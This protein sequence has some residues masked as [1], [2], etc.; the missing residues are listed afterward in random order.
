[1]RN[2]YLGGSFILFNLLFVLACTNSEKKS[3]TSESENRTIEKEEVISEPKNKF[4]Q[5]HMAQGQFHRWLT[6]NERPITDSRIKNQLDLLNTKMKIVSSAGE[7]NSKAE[8]ENRLLLNDGWKNSHHL[9]SIEINTNQDSLIVLDAEVLYQSITPSGKKDSYMVEYHANLLCQESDWPL[10]NLIEIKS[11]RVD[12]EAYADAYVTNRC[13][14][15]LY[16][17]LGY[18]EALSNDEKP[19]MA[20]VAKDFIIHLATESDLDDASKLQS[21]LRRSSSLLLTSS[22]E[23]Q[24]IKINET[25]EGFYEMQFDLMWHG[26]TKDE[27]FMAG[28]TFQ[29]W[30]V[31]ENPNEAFPQIRQIDIEQTSPFV[32]VTEENKPL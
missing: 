20:F 5:R 13:K 32:F 15:L 1:M 6:L 2:I 23:P 16:N 12:N 21:W 19:L 30:K 17:W 10:F 25:G 31:W 3:P 22:Y 18:L 28:S 7:I 11:T 14:S 24:N 9:Q 8:Y 4:C 26:Q 27:R 29:K